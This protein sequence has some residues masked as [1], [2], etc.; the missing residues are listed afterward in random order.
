MLYTHRVLA[1]LKVWHMAW[2]RTIPTVTAKLAM[3]GDAVS[4]P[5][6]PATKAINMCSENHV[7][8]REG[9]ITHIFEEG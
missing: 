9:I 6:S 1:L 5:F 8:F 2:L 7:F 4:S 3:G